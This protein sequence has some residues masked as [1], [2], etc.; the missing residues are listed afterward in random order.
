MPMP[1]VLDRISDYA[2]FHA[3]A[4]PEREALVHGAARWTYRKLAEEVLHCAASFHAAG[5]RAHRH[6]ELGRLPRVRHLSPEHDRG[7]HYRHED[8]QPPD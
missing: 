7:D 8:H 4:H 1:A 3:A 6:L 5:V 2:D